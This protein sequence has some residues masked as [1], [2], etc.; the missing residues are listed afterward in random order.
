M[1]IDP[2]MWAAL[3]KPIGLLIF[4]GL[5]VFPI[6]WVLWKLIPDGR[7]KQILFKKYN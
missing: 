6:K 2:W 3:L 7:I 5:V 4:F 1:D